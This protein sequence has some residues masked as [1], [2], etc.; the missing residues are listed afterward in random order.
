MRGDEVKHVRLVTFT[1]FKKR[2]ACRFDYQLSP[3]FT[4]GNT[5]AMH[6]SLA[7]M[8]EQNLPFD[9]TIRNLFYL[10]SVLCF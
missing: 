8:F 10:A 4:V 5:R 6:T 9:N 2:A 7:S 3:K 1:D